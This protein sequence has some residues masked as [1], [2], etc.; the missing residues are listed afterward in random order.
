MCLRPGSARREARSARSSFKCLKMLS[1]VSFALTI[2][3][4]VF[5]P[6][7]A[8]STA[9][10]AGAVGAAGGVMGAAAAGVCTTGVKAGGM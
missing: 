1:S 7:D 9:G 3:S 6:R 10:A 2:T 5:A 4:T 8:L